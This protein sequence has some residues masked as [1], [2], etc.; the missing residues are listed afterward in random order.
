M[1]QEQ[2]QLVFGDDGSASAD[3]AWLW[4]NNHQW[5]QW[6]ITVATAQR[7]LDS[8][9][10]TLQPWSPAAPRVLFEPAEGT[11]LE[12]LRANTDPRIMLDSCS[13]AGL[14]VVGPRGSGTLKALHIGSTTEWLLST[15]RPIAPIVIIRS[16]RPTRKVLLCVDGSPDAQRAADVLAG[17]PWIGTCSVTILG[18]SDGISHPE[19]GCSMAQAAFADTGATVSLQEAAA[20]RGTLTMNVKSVLLDII[21]DEG[22]DLVA[23]GTRG[24]GGIQRL[25]LGSTASAVAHYSRCSTLIARDPSAPR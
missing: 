1:S 13:D 18:V 3:V 17:L 8:P 4:V 10:T 16:A 15:H 7:D 22:P 6:R 2:P 23:L 20:L 9:E 25:L 11:T 12:H 24:Q 5:P 14:I 21:A 19:E